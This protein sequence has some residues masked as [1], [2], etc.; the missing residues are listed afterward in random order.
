[1]FHDVLHLTDDMTVSAD[2]DFFHLGGHSLL[3]T[4]VVAR[5]NSD[6]KTALTLRDVFDHPTVAGLARVVDGVGLIAETATRVGDIER[7]DVLPVSYGQE[8]LWLIDR[9]G[10]PGGRYVVPVVLRLSGEIDEDALGGAVRDVVTRHEI[11]R[12]RIVEVDGTLQQ[13]IVP[14][15]EAVGRLMVAAKDLIGAAD[16]VVDAWV[17]D[18]VRAGFDLA[19]DIPIRVGLLRTGA[20][21]RALVLAVHHHAIDE[22]SFPVLLGDLATAYA[23]RAEGHAPGWAPLPVQYADY[24]LWQREVLGDA[25]DAGSELG[26]HLEYWRTVLADA[27]EE[28][29]IS[30]D[31]ARPAEPTHRGEDIA[32][33][34]DGDTT[35][36][37]REAA[38]RHGVS[39]F[40]VAQTATAVAVSALS[41]ADDVVIGSPV[42]GRTTDGVEDLV[43]YFVNTLPLRHR[44]RPGDTLAD[45]LSRVRRTVL[46]GFA[47]QVAPFAHISSAVGADRAAGRNP[48]FQIMLTHQVREQDVSYRFGPAAAAH[49][50]APLG[51]VKA[52]LDLY[53]TDASDSLTG[54]LSYATDLFDRGTIDRFLGVLKHVL[55]MIATAPSARVADL[56]LVSAGDR[57]AI[58]SWSTGPGGEA[59]VTTL[60][61]LMRERAAASLDA[62]AVIDD[63]TGGELTFTG[64][65]ARANALAVLLMR[66]GVSVGDRVGVLLPR[67]GDLVATLAGVVR[68]GAA[69]VPLDPGYPT[70]RVG[71]ILEDARAGTV[72]TDT[73]TAGAHAGVLAAAGVS[74]LSIDDVDARALLDAGAPDAPVLSRALASS[75]AAAVIFTSG[76]TGRPKGVVVPHGS[77]VNRLTWGNREL[78]FGPG[79]AGLIKSGVG[80]VDASTELF[81]P[82]TAGASV[83]VVADRVARDP[84]ALAG[85]VRRRGVTHLLTVPSLADA[86]AG[87]ADAADA[88][89]SVR[90]WVCSGEALTPGTVGAIAQAAPG[91]VLQ[92]F[93]GSTEVT[94]DGARTAVSV[95]DA[96]VA[97]RVPIG[98]PVT[99]TTVRVLDGWL[100]PVGPG[101]VG[102]LYLGGAQLA[103]GYAGRQALTA[104]RFVA[105][106]F[107]ATGDR[108]YRT[109]DVVRWG[110]DGRLEY[111]GRSDDQVK[112]R[113]YRIE[114]DEIRHALETHP[115]VAG[116][117]VVALDHPAGGKHLAAYVTM[118]TGQTA[119]GEEL[120]AHTTAHLPEYMVPT[121]ITVLESFPLTVNGKVDR[122]ALPAPDVLVASGADGR[123]P[124]TDTEIALATVFRDVLRLDGDMTLSADDDLFRLGGHSL[125]AARVVAR[126]NALRRS[127]LTLRDVF[128]H[129]TIAGLAAAADAAT[130]AAVSTLHTRRAPRPDK[131]TASYGQQSLWITEQVADRAIYRTAIVLRFREAAD[132][133]ALSRAIHRLVGRHEILRTAFVFDDASSSLLQA[134]HEAPG[135]DGRLLAV[136]DARPGEVDA[137]IAELIAEPLDLAS[138]LGLRYRLLRCGQDDVL[139]A[140]GHHIVTDEQSSAPFARDLNALYLAELGG[141]HGELEELPVQYADFALW[142]REELGD[143]VRRDSRYRSDLDYWV[144]VLSGLPPETPLPLDRPRVE[145]GGRTVGPAEAELSLDESAMVDDLLSD[146]RATPL[147][148]LIAALS[149]T[150]WREGAGVAIPVGT[151][152]S[153]RDDPALSELIG[154]FVNTVV[155][156]ADIDEDAGF[157]AAV[158]HV[159]DR[160]IGAAEHKLVPF[161]S[162]VEA[163]NP[164]RLP[165]VSPLFQVMAAYLDTPE[166]D[167]E[168]VLV[169]HRPPAMTDEDAQATPALF[170][171]VSS[172]RRDSEGRLALHLNAARELFSASTRSRLIESVRLFLALGARHPALPVRH[173]SQLVRAASTSPSVSEDQD[174]AEF[175]LVLPSF[176]IRDDS[177][178]RAAIDHLALA[179][180][181]RLRLGVGDQGGGELIGRTENPEVLDAARI[182]LSQLVTGYRSRT[183]MDVQPA[184]V[185]AASRTDEECAEALRDPFWEEWVEELA[186][187]DPEALAGDDTVGAAREHAVASVPDHPETTAAST[188]SRVLSAVIRVLRDDGGLDG[189]AVVEITD[190]LPGQTVLRLP[191]VVPGKLVDELSDEAG[192]AHVET[193]VEPIRRHA[194]EYG[195]LS[196]HPRFGAFF[197]DL[198]EPQVRVDVFET[199]ARTVSPGD[200]DLVVGRVPVVVRVLIGSRT[201]EA[202]R[203]VR[204]E[205]ETAAGVR[206]DAPALAQAVADDL[207]RSGVSVP[208]RAESLRVRRADRLSLSLDE[209]KGVRARHGDD[210]ELLP[211][212]PL[213]QGLL[214]HM[215]RARESDDHNAYVSQATR[216]LDGRV[217]PERLRDAARIVIDR[218]PNLRASFLSS[219]EAQVVPA[220]IDLPFRI[221]TSADGMPSDDDVTAF[222]AAERQ[223]PF[224][225]EAPPLIRFTLL[226]RSAEAWTLVMTFAHI[227]LDGWSMNAVLEEVFAVY[228]DPGYAARVRPAS[229]RS[230]LDWLDEQDLAAAHGAWD[231]YLAD[232]SGPTLLWPE[233]GDLGDHQV[234]TGEIHRDLSASE[235]AAVHEAAQSAGVTIGTVLQA[236]WGITLGRLVGSGDVVFGNTVSGRPPELPDGERI[237]GLLF[238]TVP[239]RMGFSPFDAVRDLLARVQTEQLSV[240]D[241]PYASLTRIQASAGLGAL[242]DTL[243]VVQNHPFRIRAEGDI[244][245]LRVV[246]GDVDD[247]THYPVTFAVN[248][249]Q[250]EGTSFIHVR[251]SYR[252]DAFD[253]DAAG[254]VLERYVQV[255]LA[256]V[257]RLDVPVGQL[258][259]LLADEEGLPAGPDQSS[260]LIVE[261]LTVA[262]LLDAQVGRSPDA[263]ALV[264]G[265]RSFTFAE[266]SAEVNR[267][268]RLLLAHGVRPEHRVALLLPRDE[269]M[270]VAMFAVFA[271][272]AAYVPVD[273]ELPDERI[274]Y[275]LH[276]A[277]PTVTLVTS[278]DADRL[279]LAAGVAVDLDGRAVR[280][281]I[282]AFESGPITT[283]ERGGGLSLDH[284]AYIIFTSG[285]TGRPKGVAVGYRGLTNMYVNHVERI[286]DRVV[287]HQGGRR[288]KIAHTTSFSFDA[289][290]EQLFWL[291]NG[292]EVHVIDEELRRDPHRLL[293][294]YDRTRVD[295]FDVTPSYGQVLV[296]EGLLE[297]ARPAGRSV[298]A[299]APGVVFVSLG[300]E[301]VPERLWQQLRDAPGVEAY[302]LYGPTEYTINALGADLAD[303]ATPSVG[304]PIF[305]TRA[306][307]LDENLHP[308][309]PGVAGELYLAGAGTARGY[310]GQH[311]LTAERFV[312]CP[313]EPGH[314]MYRTGDLA[315][316]NAEGRIDYLGRIDEQVKIR[317]YR[318]EPDE[319]RAVLES[320]AGVTS[321]AVIA[322]DH[323]GGGVFLAAYVVAM[324]IDGW[325]DLREALRIHAE[326]RL[327]EYMVPTTFTCV[328]AFPLTPTGKLDRRALP[329]PDLTEATGPGRS[330]ETD[331]ERTL[332]HVFREVLRLGE[333][334]VFSIDDDFFRLGGDSILSIQVV[335][336]ARRAG[337]AISAAEVFSARTIAALARLADARA[338]EEQRAQTPE[339]LSSGLWPIAA[340]AV[341]LPGFRTFVQSAVFT[342]PI[343]AAADLVA[344][345]L[346]RVVDHH[347]ELRGRLV[348]Q[349]DGDW[350]FEIP[351]ASSAAAEECLSRETTSWAW[352]DPRWSDR[353]A[354]AAAEL[355]E[356]LDPEAGRLWGA[357]WVTS[358]AEP[359]GR[360]LLVVHH[361]VVDGVSW[362]IIGDD[363]ADAAKLEDGT[364]S[365]ALLT[366][367]TGLAAWSRALSARATDADIVAQTDHWSSVSTDEPLLGSREL[368]P[369][370]DTRAT[371]AAVPVHIPAEVAS[372]LLVDVPRVLS[373]QVNDVLLGSL[374]I[375]VGAWR[376]RRGLADRRVLVGLEGHGREESLV[377]GADLSRTVGWFT[378]WFP[379]ALDTEDVDPSGAVVDPRASSDVVLRIKEQL[380]A[381]PGRGIGY[382][383]LRELAPDARDALT[384]GRGPQIGFN[385]LGQFGGGDSGGGWAPA[386]E[387]PGIG[388]YASGELP[389]GTAID[390]NVAAVPDG[391]GWALRGEIAYASGVLED[392]DVREL[393]ELWEQA[394]GSLAAYPATTATVRRS[395]SDMTAPGLTQVDIDSWERRY[396]ELSDV[397]PLT[398]LQQGIVFESLAGAGTA[399]VDVYATQSTYRIDGDGDPDRFRGSLVHLLARFPNLRAAIAATA[400]GESVAVI[401]RTVDP[402][403][404]VV[405]LDDEADVE[406]SIE[407]IEERDR[408]TPFDFSIAPLI[409]AALVRH[410]GGHA[411]ILTIHHVLVDGWSTPRLLQTLWEG[412][413]RPD[414]AVEPDPGFARFLSWLI[415]RDQR[416]SL[417]RWAEALAVVEEPT[418]VAP[419][420]GG[421]SVFPEDVVIT[422]DARQTA[423]LKEVARAAGSTMSNLLQTIWAVF[424]NAMT[425]QETVVFG[426]TVSG[427]PPEVEGVEEAVGLFIN[428]LPVAVPLD[429]GASLVETV[430]RV[431]DRNA[432][433]LEHHHVSLP[434]LHRLTGHRPLFD[435]LFVYE[436]YPFDKDTLDQVSVSSGL[437]LRAVTG[438]ESTHYPLTLAA[439]AGAETW[440]RLSYRPDLFGPDEA[441]RLVTSFLRLLAVLA[442]DPHRP[443]GTLDALAEGDSAADASWSAGAHIA[444]RASTVD[445]LLR[446]QPACTPDA[447]A[448]HDDA[449]G[450]E[451]SFAAFDARVN[452]V[453]RLLTERGVEVGDRV[454]VMLPRSADLVAVLAGVIRA[455]AAS[456]PVDPA[457]PGERI[458]QILDQARAGVVIAERAAAETHADV[459]GA[460]GARLLAVDDEA[461]RSRLERGEPEAPSLSRPLGAQDVAYVIFTSGTTGRPKGV[462]IPHAAVVNRLEWGQ[463]TYPLGLGETV[464]AKTPAVFDVS[465][466]EMFAPLAFGGRLVVAADGMHKDPQYLRQRIN[467]HGVSRVNFVPSMADVFLQQSDERLD[468]LSVTMLAGE[469][470]PAALAERF[471]ESASGAL[472]NVYGPTEAGEVTVHEVRGDHSDGSAVVPIGRPIDN[473]VVRVLDSWLRPVPVGGT[474]ELYL[475]GA[476]IAHGYDGRQALTAERFVA[477]PSTASGER[478]YRTGDL[479]RWNR[480]GELEYLGRSDDQVKI[481]GF[482]VEVD[483]VRSALE[484]HPAVSA[485]VVLPHDHPAGGRF[486]AAYVV[487]SNDPGTG[488]AD[489]VET[490]RH[491][492]AT[493]LPEYMV[494]TTVTRVDAFPLTLNGKLDRRALPTPDLASAVM[495]GPGPA[496][497][498]ERIVADVFRGVL[499]LPAETALGIDDDFF[500]LGG[501]SLL[502]IRLVSQVNERT[503]SSLLLKDVLEAGSIGRIAA[504]A[505]RRAA[506]D[507]EHTNM[508][509][510]ILLPLRSSTGERYLFCAHA[511]YGYASLYADFAPYVPQDIGIVGLQ[512]PSH[513]GT[514]IDF[515]DLD[516]LA[517]TYANAIQCVQS[518]GPFDLLGWSFGGHIMFAVGRELVS[519]GESVASVTI[520]DTD[521]VEDQPFGAMLSALPRAPISAD[522]DAQRE[523]IEAH[524]EELLEMLGAD[525][526]ADERELGAFAISGVRCARLM[527]RPTRGRLVTEALFIEARRLH[528]PQRPADVSVW[529]DFLPGA[530]VIRLPD[531][532]HRSVIR[533][534]AGLPRWGAHL[535]RLLAR[536][537][538]GDEDA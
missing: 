270:V 519:R 414:S 21:E 19:V 531:E 67:S 53:L 128:D 275:M 169:P 303:S 424:L 256:L 456:V 69:Y 13:V 127:S 429:R 18:L 525:G 64:L 415:S 250:S 299:E 409:R 344:R 87:V 239:M 335:S 89:R 433:L 223:E 315:R 447:I 114:P 263:T 398:P 512:D 526:F 390:I 323:P 172:I 375:A 455:G 39:M 241:Y 533:P 341:G 535:T 236:A 359:D 267:Y 307:V 98:R 412:Y 186:E 156:R 454:A 56:E 160:V 29:T 305:D 25:D 33:A 480:D 467:G 487:T 458:G 280:E 376:A 80:F 200:E 498:G 237:I 279:G 306:Y 449:D 10:G 291:L 310:W 380:A 446:A 347:P 82:L 71:Q 288:M 12:T 522:R 311:A 40:M 393:A 38:D 100:R 507:A 401:P 481:R 54:F 74:V 378:T 222:L 216:E 232:L 494:P 27:P 197:D 190:A 391:A 255:L 235:A 349:D 316:W 513:A 497:D 468:A 527:S 96:D 181:P 179:G 426:A 75:D 61:D 419:G 431:Q 363:L 65:D 20:S 141:D 62:V 175:R 495:G 342:T 297:R 246:G 457:Y 163:S 355:A 471:G 422:L 102:E 26:K 361:L 295:G 91:A 283:A 529:E 368:D 448:V 330:A 125:L 367:G 440:L 227:L 130:G 3:A 158:R 58:A 402:L 397:H 532:D 523:F 48:L 259:A 6:C 369:L 218:H 348:R 277:R 174:G 45:I 461:V 466:P 493:F 162:V 138:D 353:V 101:A 499:R 312:A 198:P 314:R 109:G 41:G 150:L 249:W 123:A 176:D 281:R 485:A 511:G 189:D 32:F 164:P 319:I 168:A 37:L 273:T 406:S 31:R 329:A 184:A 450:R 340:S 325:D 427:R 321:A 199:E 365:D 136:E 290:W 240:I 225:F 302:N 140:H 258:S 8:A 304:A 155:V 221:V 108:L 470:L 233:G 81:G 151:P 350:Q 296:D 115:A 60:D 537:A 356:S 308:V 503:G 146:E 49:E 501:H 134:V 44:L 262:E 326:E 366:V 490:L 425:G 201:D 396:G 234:E 521:P 383:L 14:A 209:E 482:R 228:E 204:V 50:P 322:A 538:E 320:H 520:I 70:E 217:D 515:Q 187:S 212:S 388:A 173:L 77:V 11:L 389:L 269:R 110:E 95:E 72:V 313:W 214:Y 362:R 354:D 403:F 413:G 94:G 399:G 122:R 129:P 254:Q 226:Q 43:G 118:R 435:T 17:A 437:G 451:W 180:G 171:L 161:E 301:A 385:Y 51:A 384:E 292:H 78:G 85:A 371:A 63:V 417:E 111:L 430:R 132:V 154:Y 185:S 92:N 332:A 116:A 491:H 351:P 478:L 211:L 245:G 408:V 205:V 372:A 336:R 343:G 2:D 248:P 36:R 265:D 274:D 178:W 143:P 339:A 46:D 282:A 524:R 145:A 324:D 469:A 477:D 517:V 97:H 445:A 93:Y 357:H 444:P 253:A 195:A 489:I 289:S 106:L 7:P 395:P 157:A 352:S 1:M 242:F 103:D 55:E 530:S 492:V 331:T 107:S 405:D 474:G 229:F 4:R 337:V 16:D 196:R 293:D 28:S 15:E 510:S 133:D 213:Q 287:A 377:L 462:V 105:D 139:V 518:E 504:A 215:V 475:G 360:L 516:D 73:A 508:A 284:L 476:Q 224:D 272:G 436:N 473:S 142:Q 260:P 439:R 24:A 252:R 387:R 416:V 148:A 418:L 432:A 231:R 251:L 167:D 219:G 257:R 318:I 382:G 112:I 276:T 88:F 278:R 208:G 286:F 358:D 119:T 370:R 126:V 170:D 153:L 434:D 117:V 52:D 166:S 423:E 334:A 244:A 484:E 346:T 193:L 99:N 230:Y 411:L 266:F 328:E 220:K 188:R 317:G 460:Y 496:T 30:P 268:A 464:L 210:A 452:A 407:E 42:G 206:V 400:G 84:E 83:V 500:R 207:A 509:E 505:E 57:S 104:E 488:E 152:V 135:L 536:R 381:V 261:E 76:T 177:L 486:L 528:D 404:S 386:P 374:A 243:F 66:R 137:R 463:R 420:A 5:V 465:L 203:A 441:D 113:G 428:T 309:L 68:A 472:V 438:H 502:A 421:A 121:T 238:N 394:L 327:P 202:Q 364:T 149:L 131:L 147:Q 34:V 23:A 298:S 534:G 124:E 514:E 373:A 90:S 183:A 285:T 392:V 379:V 165:G 159:R 410:R 9:L 333:D 192:A 144:D 483:E 506:G 247:A 47:H 345:V 35:A 182:V 264:A 22:W 86:L 453:A 459:L 120:R 294:Y 194:E 443:L 479:V 300:G 191:V 59:P 442:E 79:D 271:V 338:G